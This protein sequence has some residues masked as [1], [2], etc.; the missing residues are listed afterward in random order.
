MGKS[1]HYICILNK[2]KMIYQILNNAN[3]PKSRLQPLIDKAYSLS[4]LSWNQYNLLI[5]KLKRHA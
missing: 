5:E 1:L 2:C 4:L 3:L